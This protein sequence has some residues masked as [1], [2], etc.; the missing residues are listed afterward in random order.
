MTLLHLIYGQTHHIE[1]ETL[2]EH[3]GSICHCFKI[4]HRLQSFVFKLK[5]ELFKKK[6]V[7][8]VDKRFELLA[9]ILNF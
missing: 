9:K 3:I 7:G 1:F 2:K 4:A 8:V 5:M 6:K